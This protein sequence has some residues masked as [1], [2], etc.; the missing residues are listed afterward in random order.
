MQ[1]ITTR[2]LIRE[3]HQSDLAALSAYESNPEMHRF[4]NGIPNIER[5]QS[6]L[7]WVIRKAGETPRTHYRMAITVPPQDIVIGRITIFSQNADIREWEM[8]WAVRVED[9]R[10]GYA[11][12]AAGRMLTFAFEELGAHRVVAF[13]HADNTGS[14]KVMEKIGMKQEGRLRETRWFNECWN[15]EFVYA[16]LDSEFSEGKGSDTV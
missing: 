15:N 5:A 3:F 12:E 7:N 11:S 4:D 9:W 1:L 8:G 13:C 10:K 16:I 2:L 14:V 6:Y